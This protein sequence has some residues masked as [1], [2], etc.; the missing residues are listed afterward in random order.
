MIQ[1]DLHQRLKEITEPDVAASSTDVQELNRRSR[2]IMASLTVAASSVQ[3]STA[4]T[5][6][7]SSSQESTALNVAAS[8]VQEPLEDTVLR[9]VDAVVPRVV[10]YHVE[11]SERRLLATLEERL[12]HYHQ[13]ARQEAQQEAR[14]SGSLADAADGLPDWVHRALSDIHA[15]MCT[16]VRALGEK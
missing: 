15:R 12:E 1:E 13:E 10:R 16:E 9:V 7:A 6:A 5:V 2:E 4:L 8:S 11:Q 14:H 3:E